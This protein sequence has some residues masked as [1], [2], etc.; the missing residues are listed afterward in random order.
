LIGYLS[1]GLFITLLF[2]PLFERV[3][4]LGFLKKLRLKAS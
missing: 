2:F 3:T 1:I 4:I